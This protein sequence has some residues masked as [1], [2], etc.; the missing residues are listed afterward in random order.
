M[1]FVG[2]TL[3]DIAFLSTKGIAHIPS[4]SMESYSDGATVNGLDGGSNGSNLFVINWTT[5]YMDRLTFMGIQ[6]Q[7]NIESYSDGSAVNG[8]N[9]GAGSWGGVYVDRSEFTG[10]SA[11]DSME[12]YSDGAALNGLNGGTGFSAAYVNHNN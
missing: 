7:D 10:L 1:S 12:S 5:P 4:D 8:L 9:G 6:A 11:S 2:L 3:L